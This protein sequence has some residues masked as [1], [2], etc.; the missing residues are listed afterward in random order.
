MNS[1]TSWF[2]IKNKIFQWKAK[3]FFKSLTD[4]LI[5]DKRV[6]NVERCVIFLQMFTYVGDD[7]YEDNINKFEN[8]CSRDESQKFIIENASYI[9]Y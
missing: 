1:Q 4:E 2:W 8:N 3:R 5:R 7:L 9:E 6:N